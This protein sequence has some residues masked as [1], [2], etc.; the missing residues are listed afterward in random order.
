MPEISSD[1]QRRLKR[2]RLLLL[3]VD[4]VLTSGAIIHTDDGQEVKSFHSHD[5]LGLNL[6][7][8]AG[9]RVGIITARRT[10]ALIHRCN[11]LGID[12]IYDGVEDKAAALKEISDN[13]G[14]DTSEISFAGDDLLDL[15]VLKRVGLAVA[16]ANA[17]LEVKEAA[18]MV[19]SARGGDGAV[20]ELCEAILKAKGLWHDVVERYLK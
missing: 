8:N 2:I 11:N 9:I 18:H 4:G 19:T 10:Q 3:D 17:R 14:L 7:M 16:V 13:L 20:R 5:G 12:L 15:P 1:L 6:L